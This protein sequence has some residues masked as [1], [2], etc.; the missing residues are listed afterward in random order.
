MRNQRSGGTR[1]SDIVSVRRRNVAA[2]WAEAIRD[3]VNRWIRS[4]GEYDAVA[5]FATAVADP[6]DP[7]ELNPAYN[8]GDFLHPNDAGYRA[9]A[10]TINPNEL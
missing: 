2:D 1:G 9:I 7:E 10:A 4:S 8:S 3:Q 6:A 5:D